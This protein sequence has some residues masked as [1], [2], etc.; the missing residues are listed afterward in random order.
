MK[1]IK[2]I[3]EYTEES[4]GIRSL[5]TTV[6]GKGGKIPEKIAL[7]IA[8]DYIDEMFYRIEK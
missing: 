6:N 3:L 8:R 5:K 7:W 2:V 1:K 4:G